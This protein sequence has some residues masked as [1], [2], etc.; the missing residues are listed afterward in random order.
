MTQASSRSS[1]LKRRK[2]LCA[3]QFLTP[4]LFAV[5]IKFWMSIRPFMAFEVSAIFMG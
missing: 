2:P 5:A 3:L 4:R 1:L